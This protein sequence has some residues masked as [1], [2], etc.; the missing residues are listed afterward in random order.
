MKLNEI[1]CS[2]ITIKIHNLHKKKIFSHTQP[3]HNHTSFAHTGGDTQERLHRLTQKNATK[4]KKEAENVQRMRGAVGTRPL[5][6]CI[7]RL[8]FFFYRNGC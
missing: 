7:A 3:L 6:R 5:T 2:K 4:T 8:Q 1:L